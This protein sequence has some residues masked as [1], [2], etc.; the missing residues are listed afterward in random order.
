M[1]VVISDNVT[2]TA[3]EDLKTFVQAIIDNVILNNGQEGNFNN[4]D[5]MKIAF[6]NN[7]NNFNA[8]IP[9]VKTNFQ[10]LD[11]NPLNYNITDWNQAVNS[12]S[13]SGI[14][15][16][17]IRWNPNNNNF[18]LTG[19]GN[20]GP[21]GYQVGDTITI[22]GTVVQDYQ[23]N[24]LQSPDNDIT[25]T[26]NNV[27]GQG[28]AQS[29]TITGT[30]PYTTPGWP[31]DNISDG[32]ND[33]YDNGNYIDTNL[34]THL[35][36]NSGMAVYGDGNVGG[37][38]YVATYQ[39][40]IFGFFTRGANIDSIG[41]SGNSGFDG[42]GTAVT[43]GLYG[44]ASTATTPVIEWTNPNNNVWRI[45]EYNGGAAVSYN[46]NDYDAKWFDV[47]NSTSGNGQFRGAIIQYHAFVQNE[48]NIIGTIHLANDYTQQQATHTENMS[49][50]G[51]LQ[52]VTLWDCN[53]E[54]GQLFFKMTNGNSKN[55]MIQW[56]AKVFYGSENNC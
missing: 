38:D 37:G 56:T 35:S 5:D 46:G 52:Y 13:G 42:S 47:S 1:L 20:G 23:G 22:P 51:D 10:F 14:S 24:F 27:D 43:G 19:G 45:E 3:T 9:S 21:G 32:G 48:G 29:Y 4:V 50:N 26:I 31:T 40:G 44:G 11:T 39:S 41:T 36:Y 55:V 7:F 17:N 2:Q 33:E 6:Y 8:I 53:N 54:R 34:G 12:G 18:D 28:I 15:I 25:V 49:G 16:G 30:V